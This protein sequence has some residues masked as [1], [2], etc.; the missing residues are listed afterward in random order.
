MNPDYRAIAIVG[1]TLVGEVTVE[2][3]EINS[4]AQVAA[5]ELWIRLGLFP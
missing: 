1:K 4:L 3:L 2:Y 5:R